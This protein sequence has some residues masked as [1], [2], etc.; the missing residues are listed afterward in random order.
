[1]VKSILNNRRTKK[2]YAKKRG[3]SAGV[4]AKESN[5]KPTSEPITSLNEA[6]QTKPQVET[7]NP[8]KSIDSSIESIS[9]TTKLA[10]EV[11]N[12][13]LIIANDAADAVSNIT[14]NDGGYAPFSPAI[15]GSAIQ[16]TGNVFKKGYNL[17]SNTIK[18]VKDTVEDTAEDVIDTAEN[19]IDTAEDIGAVVVEKAVDS[20]ESRIGIDLDNVNPE[21][22]AEDLTNKIENIEEVG[23]AL[24]KSDKFKEEIGKAG[25]VATELEGTILEQ[26]EEPVEKM[27]QDFAKRSE[28]VIEN[29]LM[30]AAEEIPGVAT[31][32]LA[33]DIIEGAD[34]LSGL[35]SQSTEVGKKAKKVVDEQQTKIN[36]SVQGVTD[37]VKEAADEVKSAKLAAQTKSTVPDLNINPQIQTAPAAAG[38]GKKKRRL[39]RKKI[40]RSAKKSM[41][42]V[43]RSLRK[44]LRSG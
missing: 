24:V 5:L 17:V 26:I 18:T 40:R 10:A 30:D 4:N 7:S 42:R 22:A 37:A 44:F 2:K 19:V 28:K 32:G 16:A 27:S 13:E 31:I 21:E 36:E 3:G 35:A 34:A 39:T 41:S 43:T 23:K 20:L 38:G 11:S 12:P 33:R 9:N 29:T 25:E 1:M 8:S 6:Q 15:W 14:N